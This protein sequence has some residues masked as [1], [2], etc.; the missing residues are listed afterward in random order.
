MGDTNEEYLALSAQEPESKTVIEK[1]Q[2]TKGK[3]AYTDD[4]A[5]VLDAAS[6]KV[7]YK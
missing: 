2:A 3:D 4:G 5:K 6:I 1:V 7:L